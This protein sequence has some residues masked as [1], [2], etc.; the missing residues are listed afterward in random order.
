MPI[1][2]KTRVPIAP[3]KASAKA[4]ATMPA[5]TAA[6]SGSIMLNVPYVHQEQNEWCWAACT[7][8]IA[9]FKGNTDVKQCEL[10]NFLH[11]QTDCCAHPDSVQ[12]NQPC[13]FERIVPVYKH[14]GIQATYDKHYELELVMQRELAAGRPFEIAFLW[15]GGGGHVVIV[16]GIDENGNYAVNDPWYGAGPVTYLGLLYAY[17]NGWWAVTYGNFR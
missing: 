5:E 10:A 12:C 4:R 8:M 2:A 9:A 16:H 1:R 3:A 14:V 11:G 17:G 6:G 7:Q 15:L 13:P